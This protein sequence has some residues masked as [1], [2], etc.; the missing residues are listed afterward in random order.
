[1]SLL[2]CV[3]IG[4]LVLPIF[5]MVERAVLIYNWRLVP[6]GLFILTFKVIMARFAAK[7]SFTYTQSAF[8]C[9]KLTI[10]TLEQGVKYVQS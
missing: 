10:E 1:M 7:N 2:I 6:F 3:R 8:T 5:A 4:F 9:T